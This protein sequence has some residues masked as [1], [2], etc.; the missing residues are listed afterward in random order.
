MGTSIYIYIYNF[1]LLNMS[2]EM[3]EQG[4]GNTGG[5]KEAVPEEVMEA[6][7]SWWLRNRQNLRKTAMNKSESSVT[8]ELAESTKNNIVPSGS[9]AGIGL[10][11]FNILNLVIGSGALS[12][13]I[14]FKYVGYGLG[15]IL[16]FIMV[17]IS[18]FTM[19]LL[20][21]TSVSSSHDSYVD[22]AE[23]SYRKKMKIFVVSLIVLQGWSF[24]LMYFLLTVDFTANFFVRIFGV[25]EGVDAGYGIRAFVLLF[26]LLLVMPLCLKQDLNDLSWVSYVGVVLIAILCFVIMAFF[27]RQVQSEEGL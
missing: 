12:I 5:D 4:V 6:F 21:I 26:A 3:E 7:Q 11:A 24:I 9:G 23:A 10:S 13:P 27:S 16:L 2:M 19:R 15:I 25:P 17:L 14:G 22:L 1:F 8:R 18:L 20:V